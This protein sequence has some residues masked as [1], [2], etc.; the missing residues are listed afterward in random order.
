MMAKLSIR[1]RLTIWYG[2]VLAV[3]LIA[4]SAVIYFT[5]RHQMLSRIDHGLDEEMADVMSE[6]KRADSRAGMLEWLDRRFGQHQGFDFQITSADGDR[7]FVNERL[8][9][10]HMPI[11]SP[12]VMNR[13]VFASY[14]RTNLPRWRI[15]TRK[16]DG[17]EGML[18]VQVARSLEFYDHEMSE[19]LLVLLLTGPLTLLVA[20]GGGYFLA[21]RAISPVDRMTETANRIEAKRLGQRI[22]VANASDELGRLADTLNGMLDRLEKSF[23]EMQRFT[24]DASHELRTPISVIRTEAEVALN[25]PVSDDEKQNLL[26][27]VLEEC[28][29]L[30]S[31]TDQLLTLS[32]EDAGIAEFRGEPVDV[33]DLANDVAETMRPLADAKGLGLAVATNGSVIV[34][35]DADRLKQVV[36][37][38]L[39][40]SIKYTPQTGHVELAVT[41]AGSGIEL[42]VRDTGVGISS[43]HLPHVFERFYRIDKA[44]TRSEGGTGLGLSIVESIVVA[45]GGRVEIESQANEGT[46]I[47]ISLP[48]HPIQQI[49]PQS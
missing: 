31:I 23:R 33:G 27:N 48:S 5:M 35:G 19:L 17:P 18:F 26:S 30:T 29:R 14:Q 25:Q 2:G 41:R 10:L 38:L 43:E 40:N 16:V 20:L 32:R 6:V 39:D 8:G 12:L 49:E 37:N 28:E 24:A 42:T 4:F 11:P 1:M 46:K 44:R 45:H 3:V 22:E 47:T 13:D 36:Y 7:V 9:D 21:R 15:V 34:A